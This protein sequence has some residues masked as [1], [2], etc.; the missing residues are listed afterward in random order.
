MNIGSKQIVQMQWQEE[1]RPKQRRYQVLDAMEVGK[2][3]RPWE[4]GQID[5]IK[6]L[7]LSEQSLNRHLNQLN[8]EGHVERILTDGLIYWGRES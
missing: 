2:V 1:P 4:I 7:N 8:D 3:Y 5:R 6:G